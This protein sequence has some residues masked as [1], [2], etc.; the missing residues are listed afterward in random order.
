M[1][2][3][4]F[5]ESSDRAD[6]RFQSAG[7]S[8]HCMYLVAKALQIF[9]REHNNMNNQPLNHR[10]IIEWLLHWRCMDSCTRPPCFQLRQ[11]FFG[12]AT[13]K[14]WGQRLW[15]AEQHGLGRWSKASSAVGAKIVRSRAAIFFLY[16]LTLFYFFKIWYFFNRDS[17][18]DATYKAVMSYA[19]TWL[20]SHA[21]CS[22]VITESRRLSGCLTQWSLVTSCALTRLLYKSCQKTRLKKINQIHFSNI[23]K[24]KAV[25]MSFCIMVLKVRVM[26]SC[27]RPV[28]GSCRASPLLSK[29]WS[30]PSQRF[31][32]ERDYP[33][34]TLQQPYLGIAGCLPLLET[35]A[36]DAN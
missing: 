5:R 21:V 1:R 25:L 13:E 29:S 7:G 30:A 6:L 23:K 3:H 2:T 28:Q 36:K 16:I 26:G 35:S 20:L 24:N 11:G 4:S 19:L 8:A 12:T 34:A 27:G 22:G 14:Q 15:G 18:F 31:L 33:W 10:V 32:P 17:P 9:R